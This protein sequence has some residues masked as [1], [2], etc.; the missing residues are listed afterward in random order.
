M[1]WCGMTTIRNDAA[2][3]G[4]IGTFGRHDAA[5]SSSAHGGYATSLPLDAG[6]RPV[7]E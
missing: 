1:I 6:G 7:P 5:E 2:G 3:V 4:N